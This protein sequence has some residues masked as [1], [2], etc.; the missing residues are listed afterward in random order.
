MKNRNAPSQTENLTV[1]PLFKRTGILGLHQH[2]NGTFYSRFSLNGSRTWRSLGTGDLNAAKIRHLALRAENEK[3]RQCGMT[4]AGDLRTMGVLAREL[5]LELIRQTTSDATK[6]N[7]RNWIARL[8]KC[9]P[10]DFDTTA[11]RSVD[12]RLICT[13]R[14]RMASSVVFKIVNTKTEKKGYRPATVNQTLNVLRLMLTIAKKRH[15]IL[16]NPFDAPGVLQSSLYLPNDTRKP[17]LPTNGDM[18]R[19]FAEMARVPGEATILPERLGQLRKQAQDSSDHARFLAYSGARLQEANSAV[20]GNDHGD[21]FHLRGTKTEDSDR[22][23]AVVPAFRAL[24]GRLA[25][26]KIGKETRYLAVKSSRGPM[27]RACKRLGLPVLRHHDLRHYF[28][29][30]CVESGVD[31]AT[32]ARWVGHSDGGVLIGKTYQHIRDLHSVEQAKKVRFIP[33]VSVA[34]S[35]LG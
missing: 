2:R 25:A 23:I 8:K 18:E 1:S 10:R 21:T 7:Y 11:A 35:T 16:D 31:C 19:I 20:L 34:R 3:A 9:W 5:E 33:L 26:D 15:V 27:A 29:T 28:I 14:D 24:L 12:A 22:H 17:V 6:R 4:I 30:V 13:L 32:I